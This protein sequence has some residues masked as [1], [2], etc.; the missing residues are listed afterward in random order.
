MLAGIILYAF[1]NARR[2]H[3]GQIPEPADN[4]PDDAAAPGSADTRR[5]RAA[6][7]E[8]RDDGHCSVPG[9]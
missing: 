1:L 8:T 4:P 7:K 2:E 9:G 5:K 6:G 3:L